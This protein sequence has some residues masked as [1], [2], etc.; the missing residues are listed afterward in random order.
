MSAR[1]DFMPEDEQAM[2]SAA[3]WGLFAGF[4]A[5]AGSALTVASAVLTRNEFEAFGAETFVVPFASALV[6]ITLGALLV[7]AASAFRKVALTDESDQVHLLRGL[8]S[9]RRYFLVQAVAT[10]IG[11]VGVSAVFA[12]FGTRGSALP[13]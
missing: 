2:S 9:L 7:H 1:I 12:Y 5:I 11:I 8:S 13:L 3:R 6:N 10:I 4:A